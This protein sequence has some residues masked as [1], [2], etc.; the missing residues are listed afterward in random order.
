[1]WDNLAWF[2][3]RIAPIAE[4][5]GVK[6]A[7]HPDDPPLPSFRG[8]A[9]I[10]STLDGLERAI[11]QAGSPNVGITFCQGN[12]GLMT[13][14]VPAAIRHFPRSTRSTSSTSEMFEGTPERFVETFHDEGPT[15]MYACMSA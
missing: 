4:A 14:D 7:L 10:L 12:I 13:D 5:S 15:D 1:M 9:R 6:V 2:L 3:E 8:V 11:E